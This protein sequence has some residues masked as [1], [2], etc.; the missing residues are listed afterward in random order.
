MGVLFD[1]GKEHHYYEPL[2]NNY[3]LIVNEKD[4]QVVEYDSKQ[5]S[6]TLKDYSIYIGVASTVN[7]GRAK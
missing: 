3:D 5:Q 1:N 7:A 6:L 4:W 2:S